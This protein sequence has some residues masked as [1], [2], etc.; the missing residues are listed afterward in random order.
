MSVGRRKS[1][2]VAELSSH[3]GLTPEKPGEVRE[4]SPLFGVAMIKIAME[5]KKQGGLP[6]EELITSVLARMRL[7]EDQFREYL[8][9]NGGLLRTLVVRRGG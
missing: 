3:E 9:A 7:P 5:L 1:T 6:F 8:A 4:V 2:R